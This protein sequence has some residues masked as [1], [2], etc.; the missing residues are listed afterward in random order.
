NW[1][2]HRV[3]QWLEHFFNSDAVA[4]F[5]ANDQVVYARSKSP[6]EAASADLPRELAPTLDLLR[7]RLSRLPPNTVAVGAPADLT[8]PSRSYSRSNISTVA[9]SAALA[10]ICRS[11]VCGSLIVRRRHPRTALSTSPIATAIPLSA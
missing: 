5:G 3:G 10:V 11:K 9:S 1:V 4:V 7:G 2:D 6:G 8:K